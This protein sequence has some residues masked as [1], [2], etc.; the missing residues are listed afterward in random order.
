MSSSAGSVALIGLRR[1][2]QYRE[3][4]QSELAHRVGVSLATISSWETGQSKPRLQHLH[5]LSK[6]FGQPV[7]VLFPD[8]AA[9]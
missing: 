6:I 4:N 2:R 1:W 7:E 8:Q 9:A 5:K 3:W